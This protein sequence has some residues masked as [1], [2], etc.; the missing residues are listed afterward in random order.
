MKKLSAPLWEKG[1]GLQ[2]VARLRSSDNKSV[3]LEPIYKT[4]R[5]L[6]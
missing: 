4:E 5:Q 2:L 1:A 6:E 3:L